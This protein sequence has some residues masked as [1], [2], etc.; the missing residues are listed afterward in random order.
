ML[1]PI[2]PMEPKSASKV[3]DSKHTVSQI[4]WDGVRI[5]T[6]WDGSKVE[7]WNRR[8]NRRTAHYPELLDLT[9]YCRAR[10]IVLD[11]E[12]I[13]LG[14]DGKPSF[15]EVMRRDALRKMDKVNLV[16]HSVP[17]TYMVF[18]ILYCN[19]EDLLSWP[20]ADRMARLERMVIPTAT[21]QIVD[22]TV[23]GTVLYEVTKQHG[24]EGIVQKR[25]DSVYRPGEKTGDWVKV[26]HYRDIVAVIGGFT[27]NDAGVVNALLLG[28]YDGSGQLIYVGHVGTGRLSLDGWRRLTAL[29]TPL[30]VQDRPFTNVPERRVGARWVKP[31]LTVKVQFA[32]WTSAMSMR[33]PSIQALVQVSPEQCLFEPEW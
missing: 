10:S 27:L 19:G 17:I 16:R 4:K 11:G 5:L 6:Y 26:K 29:L 18:D 22:S 13:A 32:E 15:H 28:L 25:L 20:L 23:D 3:T 1:S 30:E 12:V 2:V 9:A 31:M 33:Q 24:L 7:L 21:V 14:Q 8:L